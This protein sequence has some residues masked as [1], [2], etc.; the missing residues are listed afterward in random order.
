MKPLLIT[1]LLISLPILAKTEKQKEKTLLNKSLYYLDNT[2]RF[3][4]SN[5][6]NLNYSIDSFLADEKYKKS[7]NKSMMMLSWEAFQK[8]G[9]KLENYFDFKIKVHFPKASKRLSV[10]IEKERDEII[11]SRNN[12]ATQGQA[13]KDSNYSAGVSYLLHQS[14]YWKTSLDTGI[15]LELPLNPY[16]K[17]RIYNAI[18]SKFVNIYMGQKFIA[19]RNEGFSEITQLSFSK[20]LSA[21]FH[22]SQDNTLTWTDQDD[23]F[24][25]RNSL[26]LSHSIDKKQSIYY[27]AGANAYLS[28]T[29]YYYRYDVAVAYRRLLH[30]KWLYGNLSTGAEFLKDQN[31]D[32]EC[33]VLGRL[34]MLFM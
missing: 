12:T 9:Q 4:S 13:S 26:S 25:L 28:P 31:F 18:D 5:W 11:E 10:V 17:F 3:I 30:K 14:P 22:L 32:M 27:S 20:K 15:R 7:Q 23:I 6:L 24:I 21:R 2:Q 34:E 16:G 33:F 19:Y 1:L 8:E 29:Y